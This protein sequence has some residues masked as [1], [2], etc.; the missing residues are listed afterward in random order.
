MI[1][2]YTVSRDDNVYECFPDMVKTLSGK[3]VCVF[4]E[5]AHHGDL[6]G[7]R[8]VYTESLDGGKAWS[9]KKALTPR[10]NAD[11][12]YNCPRI[13]V[14][15]NGELVIIC[16]ILDRTVNEDLLK[17][18]VQ[19]VFRSTDDG[20]TWSAP[21]TIHVKGIV[22]DKYKVLS[23]GRHIFGVH[24]RDPETKRL[25]QYG[26]YSDDGGKTWTET[27]I[28]RDARYELCE[29]SIVEI[30]NG[31]LVAFMRENSGRGIC[32]MKSISKDCGTTWEG[33][34]ETNI[35]CC[36]RPV[37]DTCMSGNLFMTYR[38]MQGGKGWFGAWTQNLF[39]AFFTKETALA[40]ERKQHSVR[41]FPI[42][43][44]RSPKSDM[45]YSGWTE[46]SEGSFYVV[47]YMLDDAPKAQ[48]RG[49]AFDRSDVL[50]EQPRLD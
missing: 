27:V 40:T 17:D 29:V 26:Y 30:E 16:D 33:V 13:S 42:A 34:Y 19:H 36:H 18:C 25:T 23:G 24:R 4:R 7:S 10:V 11:F 6:N 43:Y 14:L 35:D 37:A 39:G 28:G 9:E 48:I 32:C 50:I 1:K 46:L 41:I 2:Q 12:A 47:N 5:S 45:G 3:L 38:Y 44:D 49:Y 31:T 8:L 21:E 22:P 20:T 15:P